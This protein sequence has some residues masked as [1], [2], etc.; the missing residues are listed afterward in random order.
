ME[1]E[2]W[3]GL[4]NRYWCEDYRRNSTQC[5]IAGDLKFVQDLI[6]S[7]KEQR[8]RF[9]AYRPIGVTRAGGLRSNGAERVEA[10]DHEVT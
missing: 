7:Q 9:S 5:F 2:A 6:W 3:Y 10:E 1:G 8:R 4:R